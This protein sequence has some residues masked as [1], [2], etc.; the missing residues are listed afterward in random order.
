MT[1]G[2][3]ARLAPTGGLLAALVRVFGK[4]CER[5]CEALSRRALE[6]PPDHLLD[7]VV[8]RGG[9]SSMSIE[10]DRRDAATRLQI[11]DLR[12]RRF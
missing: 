2:S 4:L 7:D 12:P 11:A 1:D 6:G 5:R 9:A 3:F 10:R 8:P